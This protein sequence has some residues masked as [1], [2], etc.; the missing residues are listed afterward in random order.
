M[1]GS[2]GDDLAEM[3]DLLGP[4]AIR[5]AA[6]LR[7]ADHIDGGV[8]TGAALAKQVGAHP[9]TL[10]KLLRYLVSRGILRWDEDTGYGV[11]DLGAPLLDSAPG[12]LRQRLSMDGLMGRADLGLVGLLHTVRTG[13]VGYTA[14]FGRDYWEDVNGVPDEANGLG[15]EASNRLFGD[16]DLIVHGYDWSGVRR[17]MDV[18]GSNGTLVIELVRAHD[19]LRGA[20]LELPGMARAAAERIE[21]AGLTGRCE[22]IAGSFLDPIPPGFDVYVL[23]AILADWRDPDATKILRRCGEA[24]GPGGRV[25]VADMNIVLDDFDPD[26]ARMSLFLTGTVP[27]PVRTTSQLK[28]LGAAAGLEVS[29]EGPATRMRTL[30]EF[31]P[32]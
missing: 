18:G 11:T 20:V 12:S 22:A 7:L 14:A 31:R 9:A 4:L 10:K 13:E 6:T 17:V 8:T 3:A 29:W 27:V 32:H 2:N 1:H 24:A 23:S 16:A 28:R 19:H 15:G 21:E 5:V 30:L 26:A 25:L